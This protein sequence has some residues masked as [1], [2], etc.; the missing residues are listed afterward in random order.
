MTN[1]R[2]QCLGEQLT[3]FWGYQLQ[4]PASRVDTL[5]DTWIPLG[6]HEPSGSLIRL[7]SHSLNLLIGWLVADQ[8]GHSVYGMKCL[9]PP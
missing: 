7:D 5:T 9:R 3:P 6:K 4:I 2:V 1:N 8:S